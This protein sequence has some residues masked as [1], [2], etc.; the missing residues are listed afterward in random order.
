M[1]KVGGGRGGESL[2]SAFVICLDSNSLYILRMLRTI[3]FDVLLKIQE[4]SDVAFHL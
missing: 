4:A 1:G 3:H 2:K